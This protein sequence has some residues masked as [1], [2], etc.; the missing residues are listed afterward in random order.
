[1]EDCPRS[2]WTGVELR[3]LEA[4]R[5]VAQEL[6][7]R[8]AARR[9]G[10]GQSAI[11]Q[12]IALLER[13]VG[14]RLV[15]RPRGGK[16]VGLTP[17][18]TLLL[19]HA[20]VILDRV[21]LAEREFVLAAHGDGA[22]LRIGVFQSVGANLLPPSLALAQRARVGLQV[23]LVD[24]DRP[25]ELLRLV[26]CGELDM[27]FAEEPPDDPLLRAHA[28]LEDPYVLLAPAE[29]DSIP[30]EPVA[31]EQ[32]AGLPLL[33]Y[34]TCFHALRLEHAL[35]EAGVQ[36]DPRVH[37]DDAPTLH[38][39]VAAGVGYALLPRLAVNVGDGRVVAYAVDDRLPRRTICLAWHRERELTEPMRVLL[40]ATK[41][42]ADA[43]R[44]PVAA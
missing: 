9:L 19:R 12:Q 33:T 13:R 11:S 4:L 27:A 7:F 1:M 31:L 21:A 18:G 16:T 32:L 24:A 28:L 41:Q 17:A 15:D 42:V 10:F 44:E 43:L 26:G 39:F 3:H 35:A 34:D 6:S 38:G 37:T 30:P 5:A 22:T 36:S 8:G 29:D 14:A 40:A 23:Q 2:G 25:S 20:E